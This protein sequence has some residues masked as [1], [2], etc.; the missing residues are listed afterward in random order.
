MESLFILITGWF[1]PII[2]PASFFLV[3]LLSCTML[4][5]DAVVSSEFNHL[6][7]GWTDHWSGWKKCNKIQYYD[8]RLINTLTITHLFVWLVS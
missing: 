2:K 5:D 1:D 6:K 3:F 8:M 7:L 4:S